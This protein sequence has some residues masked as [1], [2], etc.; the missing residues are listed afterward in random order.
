[1]GITM[2]VA[3]RYA[4]VIQAWFSTPP[5]LPTIVGI[6]V[7]TM[8]WSRLESSIPAISAEKMIQMRRWGSSNGSVVVGVGVVMR[9]PAGLWVGGV[10]RVRSGARRERRRRTP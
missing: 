5:S 8:V 4:V 3:S 1:M 7:E 2:V 10:G 9:S 6:A